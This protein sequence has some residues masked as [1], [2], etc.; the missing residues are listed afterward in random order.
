VLK[1]RGE[2]KTSWYLNEPSVPPRRGLSRPSTRLPHW[3]DIR[4]DGDPRQMRREGHEDE[5]GV[6]VSTRQIVLVYSAPTNGEYLFFVIV[7]VQGTL[8]TLSGSDEPNQLIHFEAGMQHE[9]IGQGPINGRSSL[10]SPAS[11]L[12]SPE[13]SATTLSTI[14]ATSITPRAKLEQ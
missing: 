6:G 11:G 3:R 12:S 7:G 13:R 10:S 9:G 2:G 1:H 14:I 8:W 5:R 4:G